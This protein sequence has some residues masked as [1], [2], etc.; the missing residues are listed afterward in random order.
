MILTPE[1]SIDELRKLNF[2]LVEEVLRLRDENHRLRRAVQ[3]E[4]YHYEPQRVHTAK[5]AP[6]T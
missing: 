4:A 5:G 6:M 1:L 3:R 2:E